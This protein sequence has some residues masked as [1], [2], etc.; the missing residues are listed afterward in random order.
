MEMQNLPL[1]G[2]LIARLRNRSDHELVKAAMASRG[3]VTKVEGY[4]NMAECLSRLQT[5]E[6]GTG[7]LGRPL[8][9]AKRAHDA[10]LRHRSAFTKAFG[11]NGSE[12]VR[13]V[14]AAAVAALWHSVSLLCAE[15][16]TFVKGA[17]GNYSPV[18]NKASVDEMANS[19]V[20]ARLEKFVN[21][22][23]K[24]GFEEIVTE[25]ASTIEHEAFHESIGKV[26][27]IMAGSAAALMAL[28]YIAR[29]ITEW[30]Y[31]L[32]GTATR[33]LEV[34]ARFLEMNA[35]S[36]ATAKPTARAKQEEYAAKFRALADR[37]R[38]DE[39]DAS[40]QAVKAI[41]VADQQQQQQQRRLSNDAGPVMSSATLL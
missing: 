20:I 7:A 36:I 34:Q 4:K 1:I 5:I 15:G 13:L 24:Y 6:A 38:I 27:G 8:R 2:S 25:T 22:A 23:E 37:I 39:V 31:S 3:D 9:T 18:I 11:S 30:L 35:A 16:I 19:V 14:Y 26:L 33:W 32:R 17:D 12:A 41:Q 10:L 28:L 21:A 29:D 40:K